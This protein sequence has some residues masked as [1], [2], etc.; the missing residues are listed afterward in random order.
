MN[1]NK[2]MIA[3][4]A[5]LAAACVGSAAHAQSA[6]CVYLE[7]GAGYAAWIRV[8]SGSFTSEWS[9]SFP[10]GQYRCV[11]MTPIA[12]GAPYTVQISAVLGSSQVACQPANQTRSSA[13]TGSIT[14]LASG[15]SLN[16][17]CNM[18][19]ATSSTTVADVTPNPEGIKAAE[20]IKANPPAPPK[21]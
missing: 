17:K 19:V 10:I 20:A 8:V 18:P 2:L 3:R 16:V 21:D 5:F 11:D 13:M 6:A 1:R 9:S 4:L 14:F 7:P 12:N 15:T